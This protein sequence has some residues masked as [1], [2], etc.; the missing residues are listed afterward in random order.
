MTTGKRGVSTE[1]SSFADGS[2]RQRGIWLAVDVVALLALLG[3]VSLAFYP[4]YGTPWLFVTVLGFGAVGLG[5]AVLSALIRPRL[6]TPRAP[7]CGFWVKVAPV[8]CTA[9]ALAPLASIVPVLSK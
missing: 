8:R 2:Q 5:I 3:L 6:I 1:H 9:T 7:G 4:V